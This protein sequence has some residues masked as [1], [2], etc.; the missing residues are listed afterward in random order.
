MRA[1]KTCLYY[2]YGIYNPPGSLPVQSVAC[3]REKYNCEVTI[4]AN[5]MDTNNKT[6]DSKSTGSC[7]HTSIDVAYI[8]QCTIHQ[9]DPRLPP[10][11]RKPID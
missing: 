11:C 3:Q 9:S 2:Y 7:G 8:V 6:I 1:C 5:K 10:A 4:T